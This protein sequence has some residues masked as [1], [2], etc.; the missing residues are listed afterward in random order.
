QGQSLITGADTASEWVT[1]R[2][3]R[4]Q[5]ITSRN[6]RL[7]IAVS[8]SVQETLERVGDRLTQPR[9][10]LDEGANNPAPASRTPVVNITPEMADLLL[11]RAKT[12]VDELTKRID[13]TQHSQSK[14]Y[15]P[16]L[17]TTFG[18]VTEPYTSD[19]VLCYLEGTDLK[20]ELLVLTAHYDHEG[21]QNGTIYF[22]ADHNG[23]G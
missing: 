18:A 8:G 4:L 22:G 17:K 14:S 7:I 21:N 5:N 10:A 9:I 19:N 16:R 6:P 20:D 1:S 3:K 12:S 15:K 23:S 13:E 2:T 11:A